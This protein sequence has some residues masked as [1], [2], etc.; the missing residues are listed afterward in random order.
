MQAAEVAAQ[1]GFAVR[2]DFGAIDVDGES[3]GD[4]VVGDVDDAG[5]VLKKVFENGEMS[6]NRT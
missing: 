6:L 4:R 5:A 3:G 1:S 2:E